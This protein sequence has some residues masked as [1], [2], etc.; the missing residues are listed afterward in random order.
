MSAM[1]EMKCIKM[2][3]IMD[4]ETSTL[5]TA[6]VAEVPRS[7][8]WKL[9]IRYRQ[10]LGKPKPF[11]VSFRRYLDVGRIDPADASF[12]QERLLQGN[13]DMEVLSKHKPMYLH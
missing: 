5:R 11:A 7:V 2:M 3:A 4:E 9:K 13:N 8:W 1:R 12:T 10:K 6:V